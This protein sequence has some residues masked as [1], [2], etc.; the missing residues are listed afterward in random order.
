M[1]PK[2]AERIETLTGRTVTAT[3]ADH[4]RR[5]D[6]GVLVFLLEPRAAAA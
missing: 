1:G 6:A 3:L 4:H 5:P 2:A